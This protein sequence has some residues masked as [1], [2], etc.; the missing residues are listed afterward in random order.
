MLKIDEAMWWN[1]ELSPLG[2]PKSVQQRA[3]AVK[4]EGCNKQQPSLDD[5][6]SLYV[7]INDITMFIEVSRQVTTA[8]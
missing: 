1:L 3:A 6:K 7:C 8:C 2:S 5:S 4:N